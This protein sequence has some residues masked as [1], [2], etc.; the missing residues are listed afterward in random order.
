MYTAN[1]IPTIRKLDIIKSKNDLISFEIHSLL[2]NEFLLAINDQ[3]RIAIPSVLVREEN[4][5]LFA[6]TNKL[7][8]TTKEIHT[9]MKLRD[10]KTVAEFLCALDDTTFER[11]SKDEQIFE[12]I[13]DNIP[14]SQRYSSL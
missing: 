11:V 5:K 2:D 3:M 12:I 7:N 14:L 6:K 1:N 8:A 13:S 4:I 10:R 9:I